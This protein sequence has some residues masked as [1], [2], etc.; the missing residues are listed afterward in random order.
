MYGTV[1]QKKRSFSRFW[2]YTYKTLMRFSGN[3]CTK[4]RYFNGFLALY[5][6]LFFGQKIGQKIGQN[7]KDVYIVQL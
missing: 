1:F 7:F 4:L 2:L 3:F 6:E 5:I